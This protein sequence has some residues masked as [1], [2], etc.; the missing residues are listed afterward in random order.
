MARDH[1]WRAGWSV[2]GASDLPLRTR[3]RSRAA[4]CSTELR[5][6]S[7]GVHLILGARLFSRL[8]DYALKGSRSV[9][10]T[11]IQN[12]RASARRG[13]GVYGRGAVGLHNH[14]TLN[15]H[16]D[17]GPT[18]RWVE[19]DGLDVADLEA[20]HYYRVT[21]SEC[22]HSAEARVQVIARLR[23]LTAADVVENGDC[24]QER[25]KWNFHG[26]A[27]CRQRITK[28]AGRW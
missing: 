26:V 9:G 7:V 12:D 14:G 15:F 22:L 1:R 20:S 4:V 2:E 5:R 11:A 23:F 19:H 13:C 27:G 16:S 6:Q 17:N 21:N 28:S 25:E 3:R 24:H 8:E 18:T 10:G